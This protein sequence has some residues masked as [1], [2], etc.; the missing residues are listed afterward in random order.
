[1][2]LRA[3]L[4]SGFTTA[5]MPTRISVEERFGGAGG[6]CRAGNGCRHAH[7]DPVDLVIIGCGAGGGV[8][9]QRLARRGWRIMVLE[10]GP[11]WD[12]DA[13]WVSDEAGS[14]HLYWTQTRIIGGGD[15][16]SWAAT[17]VAAGWADR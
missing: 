12:P 14:Q 6:R 1:M 9:A 2:P 17:T 15:R 7:D 8:L 5:A 4:R 13:D 16:S 11:F 10:A 3:K